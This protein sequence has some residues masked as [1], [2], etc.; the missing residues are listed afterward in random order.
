M[1][2]FE[3]GLAGGVMLCVYHEYCYGD[4]QEELLTSFIPKENVL[5]TL[6]KY[7]DDEMYKEFVAWCKE[8]LNKR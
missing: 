8:I 3:E 4:S 6:N 5:K 7:Y 2:K 1:K